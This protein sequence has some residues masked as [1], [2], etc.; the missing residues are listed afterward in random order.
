MT[1]PLRAMLFAGLGVT[2]STACVDLNK[3]DVQPSTWEA[4][5]MPA[6]AFPGLAGQAAAVVSAAGTDL[7]VGLSGATPGAQHT[8][9]LRLG[10]CALAGQQIGEDTD[11]PRPAVRESGR[12]GDPGHPVGSRRIIRGGSPPQHRRYDAAC[13]RE[14][15]AAVIATEDSCA[16]RSRPAH[17]DPRARGVLPSRS[18]HRDTGFR[19]RPPCRGCAARPAYPG[20]SLLGT[21]PLRSP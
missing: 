9:A 8:W 17:G 19:R 13:L 7:G 21:R 15:R 2:L 18:L 4:T 20:T 11:Y 12:R 5:L 14:P 3:N 10:T 1:V 6:P 16:Q